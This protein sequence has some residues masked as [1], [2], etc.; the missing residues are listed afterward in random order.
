M[1]K[2]WGKMRASC[3]CLSPPSMATALIREGGHRWRP[4]TVSSSMLKQIRNSL[5]QTPGA[6]FSQGGKCQP[7]AF[8]LF[9]IPRSPL[10]TISG[11]IPRME[12]RLILNRQARQIEQSVLSHLWT[13]W[14]G[15]GHNMAW[16]L[17]RLS[18]MNKINENNRSTGPAATQNIIQ[19]LCQKH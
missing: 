5:A 4:G 6:G 3:C 8:L 17:Q 11:A 7:N 2:D 10:I 18:L 12:R 19:T 9:L 14:R 15:D 16:S 1:Q 13:S